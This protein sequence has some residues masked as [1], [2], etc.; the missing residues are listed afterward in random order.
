MK[1]LQQRH[2]VFAAIVVGSGLFCAATVAGLVRYAFSNESY[3]HIVLI[4]FL[5]L[6]VVYTD[7]KKIFEEAR[8]G[9]GIGV[10][11][12]AA[13]SVAA[14][15]LDFGLPADASESD[16]PARA[17]AL[18]LIWMGGYL[19]CYGTR[20]ARAAVFP[21]AFLLLMIPL[22][23]PLLSHLLALLQ[24]GSADVAFWGIKAVGIPVLR[25]GLFLSVPGVV[26]QVAVE[27]S[28]IRS[29]MGLLITCLLA[30]HYFLSTTWHKAVFV[31]VS[32]PLA[33]VKNGIRIATLTFLSLRVDPGFLRGDLHRD[34]GF[35][36][37]LLVLLVMW[38]VL[39]LLQKS[40]RRAQGT[41]AGRLR[42]R[43]T[44]LPW[45]DPPVHDA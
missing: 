11:I 29:S 1:S 25:E 21:L 19:L 24:K 5:S 35:V 3:T 13:A 20:S 33:I 8:T 7:R 14:G 6:F 32:L 16:L 28:G 44:V 2:L 43:E 10:A 36:F 37:F 42:R 39:I 34:G 17:L 41:R 27:C 4:P 18:L 40:E 12:I 23:A 30:A 9:L 38:P 22:P 45:N 26:I 31:L 15:F